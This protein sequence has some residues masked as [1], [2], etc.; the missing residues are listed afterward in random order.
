MKILDFLSESCVLTEL[1]GKTK[2][3]VVTELI[4]VLAK[5]KSQVKNVDKTVEA[6]MKRESTGS[7]GIGQGVAIPHAKSEE[8]S[9]IVASLGISKTG[10]DFDSLDGE[11]VYIFFLM[12]APPESISEHLQAIAKISRL[13]KDKFFRQSLRDAQTPSEIIKIIKEEDEL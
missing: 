7:T 1:E 13:L 3:A 8:V 2:K 12:V 10:V 11:P 6:I 4:E 9:K 5:K